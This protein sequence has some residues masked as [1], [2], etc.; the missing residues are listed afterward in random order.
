[1]EKLVFQSPLGNILLVGHNK[2]IIK[3]EMN[4]EEELLVNDNAVLNLAKNQIIEYFAGNR[5]TLDFPIAYKRSPFDSKV[6]EYVK[7][8]V[9]GEVVSYGFIASAIGHHG[10]ARAVGRAMNTN[11][12]PLII[13]C[14]RVVGANGKMV[15]FAGGIWMK[16]AL[17]S[18]ESR[19]ES[20]RFISDNN[21]IIYSF[22]LNSP[23]DFYY[24]QD[25]DEIVEILMGEAI[26]EIEQ[27]KL[28]L[29][30]G[31]KIIIAA[32]KKHRVDFTSWDCVWNCNYLR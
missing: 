18:L 31:D 24:N 32:N 6:Y 4:T 17:L 7:N 3:I 11:D 25:F 5:K 27:E 10:A 2:N 9:Y 8:I 23:T 14:H 20:H 29:K 12:L 28:K 22:G 26:L 16:E 21:E 19:K 13:P 30:K 1:M 15:G